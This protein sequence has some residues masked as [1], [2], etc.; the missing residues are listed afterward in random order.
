MRF[1][2]SQIITIFAAHFNN[3]VN[4]FGGCGFKRKVDGECIAPHSFLIKIFC[5]IIK[6]SV[7][8]NPT[9]LDSTY[10]IL[11]GVVRF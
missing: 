11:V 2:D 3:A 5:G 7:Y 9:K 6:S 8:N 10:Y 4:P 1:V